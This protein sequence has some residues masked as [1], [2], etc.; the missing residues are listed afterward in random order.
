LKPTLIELC[1]QGDRNG[2]KELYGQY[3]DLVYATAFKITHNVDMAKDATQQ[4]FTQ[5][6]KNIKTFRSDSEIGTWLYRIASNISL[7]AIKHD[8]R[9]VQLFQENEASA[10]SKSFGLTERNR[11]IAKIHT[12]RIFAEMLTMFSRDIVQTF[13][14]FTMEDVEQKE[15]AAIQS[16]ALVTVKQRLARVRDWLQ[17]RFTR[18]D[19]E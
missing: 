5:A 13:W 4:V 6:F 3:V 7:D 19:F 15:I 12:E 17:K 18:E 2:F 9:T 16:I 11:P 10:E 1:K 14:L 8:K